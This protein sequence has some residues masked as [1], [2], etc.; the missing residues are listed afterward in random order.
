MAHVKYTLKSTLSVYEM[1][2]ILGI[3]VFDKMPV[4]EL[5]TEMQINQ[6]VKEQ[7]NLFSINNLLTHQ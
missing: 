6:N 4:K 2:Q 7:A 3:S 5:L 1:M